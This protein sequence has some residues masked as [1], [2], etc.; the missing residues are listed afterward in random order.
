MESDTFEYNG[1]INQ[2]VMSSKKVIIEVHPPDYRMEEREVIHGF[3]CPSC[4]G[5]GNIMEFDKKDP[6]S[7]E[8]IRCGGSGKLRAL[9]SIAF[10]AEKKPK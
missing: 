6:Y 3:V 4:Y 1:S 10:E 9:V 7:I 8:C 5:R 2:D